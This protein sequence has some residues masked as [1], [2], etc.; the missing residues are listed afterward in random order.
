MV[1]SRELPDL[2]VIRLDPGDEIIQSLRD[3]AEQKGIAG[4]IIAGLGAVK[5]VTLGFYDPDGG[6][7]IRQTFDEPLEICSAIGSISLLENS[8]P[9][10]HLHATLGRK[11]FQ[12]IGG[13]L[14]KAWI[15]VTGEFYC[16]KPG[17][18]ISRT[19]DP[20]TGFHLLSSNGANHD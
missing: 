8:T 13:H 4:G 11:N 6:D 7:Y 12:V 2:H 3:F 18:A 16:L 20:E 9:Y 14:F 5:N 17:A 19:F 15:T 10:I 1:I